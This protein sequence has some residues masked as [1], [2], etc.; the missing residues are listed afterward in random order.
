MIKPSRI[1]ENI[2]LIFFFLVMLAYPIT[3]YFCG[4][5]NNLQGAEEKVPLTFATLDD[6]V[7]QNFP[8]REYL[9]RTKNQLLYSFFDVS[10]NSSI[11]KK[12]D[13]LYSTEALNYYL[14]GLYDVKDEEVLQTVN[15][16]EKVRQILDRKKKQ[17]V[18]VITPTKPRFAG[19]EY[20]FADDVIRAY[21]YRDNKKPYDTLKRLLKSTKINCFDAIE[22]IDT[23]KDILIGGKVPLFYKSSH[24]WSTYKGNLV[25][26]A[27]LDFLKS[28]LKRRFPKLRVY[29]TPSETAVYPDQ[30]LFDVLNVYEKP[31]EQFYESK[32]D[33]L[34]YDNENLGFTIQG[35]SF[36]GGLLLPLITLSIDREVIHIENKHCL[37]NRYMDNMEFESYDDLNN[38]LKILDHMKTSEIF[39][40]EINELNVYNATF[41][42]A[43]YII[44]HE[45][46]F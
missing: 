30:D 5:E 13:V 32:V 16:L 27:F 42:F 23:H 21:E 3:A 33:F 46:D 29:A 31:N 8:G 1:I 7:T 12:G 2:I 40:F 38:K 43:D 19:Y 45:K 22:Y 6:W 14:H 10:P 11:T 18:V 28:K 39:I 41:G 24:H 26:L 37:Y 34:N 20:P 15:K 25:G 44:E 17:M 35:G 36:L 4:V 9:V